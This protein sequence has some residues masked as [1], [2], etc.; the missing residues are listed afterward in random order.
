MPDEERQLRTGGGCSAVH[1]S[2]AERSLQAAI[3][4][5]RNGSSEA[6][7]DEARRAAEIA[8]E[9][10][11]ERFLAMAENLIGEI[12]W[13]RGRWELASR[14]F[15]AAREHAEGAADAALLLL[16]E[17]NDAAVWT[18]LGQDVLARDSLT[19]ALPRLEFLDDHPA[20][21]RI[22][23]NLARALA[24]DGQT[25]AADGLLARGM[26]IAK[27]RSDFGEGAT[28]AI[29]RTRH[30]MAQG[31]ALRAD[32]HMSTVA[33]LVERAESDVLR[34]DAACLEGETHRVLGRRE[35]AERSLRLAIELAGAS[36]AA[37]VSA[38]AWRVLAEL[39]LE[40]ARIDEALE[41]LD[42]ARAQFVAMG[43]RA[44]ADDTARRT[45]D[46]RAR[47]DSSSV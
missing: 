7:I 14:L 42:A 41:A 24:A 40:Q 13:E 22:L 45:A 16:V 20:A 28:L 4:L 43:A 33:A 3:V 18:D 27:L 35:A 19:A 2:G 38:R 46:V 44:W 5:Q 21:S 29:E 10:G 39:L 30:A 23:R 32:A 8:R 11:D 12:E 31:D 9:S 15:G 1:S 6:A 17:S 26:V 34:A 37:G 25:T 47:A 36:N